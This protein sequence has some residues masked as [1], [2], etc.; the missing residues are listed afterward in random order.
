MAK[1]L[2]WNLSLTVKIW[3]LILPSQTWH[4]LPWRS[5]GLM[6]CAWYV[7]AG[8]GTA[9][10]PCPPRPRVAPPLGFNSF[11]KSPFSLVLFGQFQ[12]F[13][14]VDFC[15]RTCVFPKF[16]PMRMISSTMHAVSFLTREADCAISVCIRIECVWFLF[17]SWPIFREV[18][19]TLWNA[20]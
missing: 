3:N 5:L 2:S 15:L 4:V 10:L 17:R 11:Q 13:F 19:S 9:P 6:Q 1:R 14:S 8:R 20:F 12:S 7:C 18:N 16:N